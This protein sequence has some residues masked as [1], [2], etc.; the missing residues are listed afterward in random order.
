MTRHRI[1]LRALTQI[2]VL[3]IVTKNMLLSVVLHHTTQRVA[4]HDVTKIMVPDVVLHDMIHR[5]CFSML[6]YMM[7]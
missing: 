2:V 3:H 7:M 4:L 1:V 6:C 5:T